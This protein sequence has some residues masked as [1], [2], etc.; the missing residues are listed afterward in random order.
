M[1]LAIADNTADDGTNA[2]P[3]VSTL[4][5]KTRL[6]ARTVQRIVR[7]LQQHGQIAIEERGGRES[8]RYS[9][10]MREELSTPPANR[11]PRQDDTG[12][13]AATA[14]VAKLDHPTP[15]AA[16]SPE[17]P[18]NVLEPSSDAHSRMTERAGE[19]G[20]STKDIDAVLDGL[21]A[22][23]PLTPAQRRRLAPKVVEA[24]AAGWSAQRLAAHLSAYPEGVRSPHAVLSARLNDLPPASHHAREP[25]ARPTWCGACD[26]PSRTYERD[27]GRW[28]RCPDCHPQLV[29]VRNPGRSK[30]PSTDRPGSSTPPVTRPEGVP[31]VSRTAPEPQTGPAQT[32]FAARLVVLT[33]ALRPDA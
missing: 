10:L 14:G 3:S 28:G 29:D 18:S 22:A 26:E 20:E 30:P 9:I 13:T 6:D 23:W 19:E 8:N 15:G 31:P 21:G 7:K 17:P 25:R 27:D 32:A 4:A 24:L 2:Y 33:T 11:H 5:R 12:G 16:L 1:L